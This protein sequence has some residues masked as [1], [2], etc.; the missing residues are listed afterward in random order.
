MEWQQENFI[1]STDK[2]K[3]NIH[4]IHQFLSNESYWAAG[5]PYAIVE[6][7]IE[8]SLCFGIYDGEKQI[9]FARIITDEATFGYLAD[10]F[11]DSAYRRRGLGKWLMKIISDLPFRRLLRNFM[12][13]TKDAHKLYEQFGFTPLKAPERF[14][15]VHQ[16]NI[17]QLKEK[18]LEETE[19]KQNS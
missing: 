1:I 8:N 10:V 16:P 13:G 3:L 11:V 5:I 15:Q 9:G 14:M 6:K 7:S 2:S 17:Y 4:Y 19:D 12:L 18:E